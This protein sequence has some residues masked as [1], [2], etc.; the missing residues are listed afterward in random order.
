[1][2]KALVILGI[3]ALAGVVSAA[4]AD[5]CGYGA[6]GGMGMGGGMMNG[7][8]DSSMVV[9]ADDGSI[10]VIENGMGGMGMMGGWGSSQPTLTNIEPSGGGVRWQVPFS[11]G[12]PMMP[13]TDGN[14][15]VVVI[16]PG[17]WGMWGGGQGAGQSWIVGID[18]AT[19]NPRWQ[20]DLDNSMAS[21]PQ[22][23]GDGSKFYVTV[24]ARGGQL[25]GG[26]M[27]QGGWNS[28]MSSTLLAIDR[29]GNVLWE[30]D[31]GGQSGGGMP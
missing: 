9:V 2:K 18:L 23:S 21:Y 12:W 31:L 24:S 27:E 4:Q 28:D 20:K 1:M 7:S 5:A 6:N 15:V 22:F 25:G 3:L 29:N 19:G 11:N 30:R 8:M 13:I 14:L 16:S 10:L 26:P 17:G